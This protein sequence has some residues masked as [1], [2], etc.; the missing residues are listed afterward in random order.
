[1]FNPFWDRDVT[2]DDLVSY[3]DGVKK[4]R[5]ELPLQV[6]VLDDG[7]QTVPGD[8]TTLRPL[9]PHG[10][11]WLTDRAKEAGIR[12]G[13]WIGL[14]LVNKNSKLFAEHPD[15]V[16][17][18]ADGTPQCVCGNW[19]T[20]TYSLDISRKDVLN[21]IHDLIQTITRDWGFQ[22]I[23]L[24]FN[25]APSERRANRSLTQL[26]AMRQMYQT[27]REAAGPDVFISG[28]PG[29]PYAVAVGL[30]Q[31]GRM[32]PDVGPNW[33]SVREGSRES[34]LRSVFHRRWVVNDPDTIMLRETNSSLT[35]S[36]VR[37][38]ATTD[39]LVGGLTQ[40]ADP[41]LDLPAARRRML[42]Q[43]LPSCGQTARPLDIMQS[44]IPQ[45][46]DLPIARP[47]GNWHVVALYNWR[48]Q[49]ADI[50]LD[51]ASL[52]AGS[53]QKISLV[54]FLDRHLFRLGARQLR[55][56]ESTATFL[57]GAVHPRRNSQPD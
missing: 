54:R 39:A 47:F 40:F 21:H 19:G 52:G 31:S 7:Y 56:H 22:Y 6:M 55:L 32:G 44:D 29:A 11:K 17:R 15:W 8:W 24:D 20:D 28:C 2:E 23:K 45:V 46:F 10:M 33:D 37:V 57:S 50:K 34:L 41:L 53:K 36:E 9:F 49:P 5:S 25:I 18:K 51:L 12:P 38:L 43:V 13:L 14:P 26:Q 4:F 27:V 16:D 42:G 48:D 1:M 35:L 3:L 30:A